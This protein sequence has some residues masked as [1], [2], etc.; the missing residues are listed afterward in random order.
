MVETYLKI[1]KFK[2]IFKKKYKQYNFFIILNVQ[3]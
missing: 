3:K 2:K 1:I